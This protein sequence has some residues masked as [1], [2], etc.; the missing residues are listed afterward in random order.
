MAAPRKYALELRER[1]VQVYRAAEP[2]PVVRRIAEKFGVH[3]E[4]L[5]GWIRKAEADAGERDGRLTTAQRE[6]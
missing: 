5:H 2:R 6:A 4:A 1:A 3:P